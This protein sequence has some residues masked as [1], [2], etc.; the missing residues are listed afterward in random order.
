MPSHTLD[1]NDPTN[2]AR[3]LTCLVLEKGGELRLKAATYDSYEH[4]RFLVI[5]FDV[6]ANE[7]VLR[8]TS[9]FG[10]VVAVK[11]E[12]AQWLK[13]PDERNAPL[14][15]AQKNVQRRTLRSDAELAD[16]EESRTREA[17]L[18]REATEGRLSARTQFRNEVAP[19]AGAPHTDPLE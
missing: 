2:M 4:S 18:A 14:I 3:I 16:L 6:A 8:S 15:Q 7:I 1:P 13:T 10:R 12:N 9:N 17:Q 19:T 5:D 11:A